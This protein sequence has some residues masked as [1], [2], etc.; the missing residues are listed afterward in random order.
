MAVTDLTVGHPDALTWLQQLYG[1]TETGWLTLFSLDRTTGGNHV[2]WA[3]VDDLPAL[4]AAAAIRE[5]AGCVWFGV[6]TRRNQ[7]AGRR[8][9][10]DDCIAI[11]ALW[12]DIDIAGP[13][14]LSE[15]RLARDRAHAHQLV[16]DFPLPPTVVIDTGGGLQPW[17][18]FAEPVDLDAATLELLAA[19]GATWTRI[20]DRHDIDL[21]NVFDPARV[22][23][24]PGTTNRKEGLARPVTVVTADW[25]RRYGTD[26]IDQHLEAAAPPPARPVLVSVPTGDRPG[27]LWAAA[28]PWAQILEPDGWTLHHVDPGGEEHWTRPG[29]ERREGSSATVNYLGSDVLKVFTSSVPQLTVDATYSKLGYL[30]ATRHGGDHA[31]AASALRTAGWHAPPAPELDDLIGPSLRALPPPAEPERPKLN[32][33][34]DFWQARPELAHIRQAAHARMR[35]ADA[36]FAVVLARL[37]ALT[38]PFVQLPRPVGSSGTLDF[39]VALIGSSGSGKSSAGRTAEELI[40]IDDDGVRVV[41][42]GSGEG[43]IEAFFD[44]ET[45]TDTDGKKKREKQQKKRAVL[46]MLDEGQALAEMGGRKGSTLL[47][48]IRSA[49]SGDLL[50]QA[51][52]SDE[53][54]RELKPGKYRFAMVAGF[55]LEHATGLLDDAAG[56][57]PQRFVFLAAQ[58]PAIPRRPGPWPGELPW[59]ARARQAGPLGLDDA[60]A[61]EIAERS[62]LRSTGQVQIDPLDS[63]RDL[64]RLKV[65]SLLAILGDRDDVDP[66]DWR[67]AGIVTDTSDAVRASIVSA[68][69][70]RA[71]EAEQRMRG[72]MAGRKAHVDTED[73]ARALE[74]AARAMARHVHRGKCEGG[75]KRRCV[76]RAPAGKHLKECT[77]D[78]AIDLARANGWIVERDGTF[79]KG[80]EHP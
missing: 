54:K 78:D 5:P 38:A 2:D 27:D 21:D 12:L 72:Q 1:G 24:L 63:H 43:L 42:L 30:A 15:N 41:P 44:W 50:G 37:A 31:A 67:L 35:S 32:L 55:Q 79:T 39:L 76:S 10:A 71:Q 62:W 45:I 36:V 60:V 3:T 33:P 40:D 77:A 9:G 51:N 61:D 58:D 75:C 6:A 69:V 52:A 59:R 64:V 66:E 16:A 20:A 80:A 70:W 48:T 46:A 29:K 14:H 28:T 68:A 17:W 73:A 4:A 49:W 47:T 23:R 74:G 13:G 57:T 34:D 8:G 26:D 56:G 25:D 65:A 19:W 18:L 11:P 22:M 7:L 53:R